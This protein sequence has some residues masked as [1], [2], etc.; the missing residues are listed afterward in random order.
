MKHRLP[1]VAGIAL[2]AAAT[3]LAFTV[4][5]DAGG[6]FF[7]SEPNE[8]VADAAF[9]TLDG[10]RGRLAE[11]YADGILVVAVRDVFCPVASRYAPG[12]GALEDEYAQRGVK[13]L[14]LN[15]N[16]SDSPESMRA[17]MAQHGFDGPYVAGVGSAVAG[18]L[19]PE[20]SSEVFV[21]D[22]AGTLRYRGAID[23]QYGID[24]SKPAPRA[25]PLRDA[26]DAV[27]A[28]GDPPVART[29]AQGCFLPDSTSAEA[30]LARPLTYHNRISRIVQQ[31]CVGCHREEGV[32][33]FSLERY[34]S[35]HAR[36]R[37]I[38]F[39]TGTG[40]MPPWFAHGGEWSNDRSLSARDLRDLSAWLAADAPEGDPADA[41]LPRRFAAGWTIGK[42][43]AV[44]EIP[45]SF[46]VPATGVVDY[47]YM[48]VK[49]DFGEDKWVKAVE[50]LPTAP[51]VTHH[52][53]VLIEPPNAKRPRDAAPGE[54]IWRGGI[55]GYF[56]VTAPGHPGTVFADGL[57]KK[58]PAGAW[59]KFQLHYNPNG[60]AATDRSRIGLVFA[61]EPPA[62]EILT[63]SVYDTG[64]VIPPGAKNFEVMAEHTF[65]KAGTLLSFFPHTHVRGQAFRYELV[66]PDGTSEVLLDIPRYDFNWQLNYEFAKP[67][68]V[69]P[70]SK[71][72]ARAWY[73]NSADNRANPDPT[74]AVR[75]GEQTFEEMMIG[76]FDWVAADY[77]PEAALSETPSVSHA[78][79]HQHH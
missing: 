63:D 10:E 4:K 61:A 24:F 38:G 32:A 27:L 73:D 33:P 53:L 50:I 49:T 69:Q 70:G 22:R 64:F 58:L 23:D 60:T 3:W 78:V 68:A 57:A 11:L 75:F 51:Q 43:D 16:E 18:T 55:D 40:R 31:N 30:A 34:E 7:G 41:P 36:R 77:A 79:G 6:V 20:V 29:Q 66:R 39:M 5:P 48:Y 54:P 1:L 14:Y 47:Q 72:R 26:L 8:L 2:A 28:G 74:A 19:K 13:F 46:A 42:P 21:I 15:M 76:Y 67:H 45:Q 35:V 25:T 52:V 71:L 44:I 17:E 9:R 59:L 37:M 56:A 12:L 65:E 62:R